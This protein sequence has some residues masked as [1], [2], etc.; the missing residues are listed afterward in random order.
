MSSY[1]FEGKFDEGSGSIKG[2]ISEKSSLV[3]SPIA[4][5]VVYCLCIVGGIIM[6]TKV[7][8]VAPFCIVPAV[9]AFIVMLIPILSAIGGGSFLV[10]FVS[11][12]YK[13]ADVLIG[14]FVAMFWIACI[15][16]ALSFA[17]L[18]GLG[19]GLMYFTFVSVIK[20][21]EKAGVLGGVL[22]IVVPFVVYLVVLA[23]S[24]DFL[25]SYFAIIP[26]ASIL[27]SLLLGEVANIYDFDLKMFCENKVLP[28]IKI[29]IYLCIVA[30]MFL[31]NTLVA[32]KKTELIQTA[33][34]YINESKYSEARA[35]LQDIKSE[36]AKE[37]Y[38][39]IR[40][41]GVQVGEI[42]YNGYYD[43]SDERSVSE[44]AIAFVCLDVVDNK[45]LFISLDVISLDENYNGVLSESVYTEDF[46]F[47]TNNMS[48][49]TIN[50]QESKFFLLSK[51][52]YEDYVGNEK[53]RD[54]LT[55]CKVS[56]YAQEQKEDVDEEKY[57]WTYPYT[58]FWLLNTFKTEGNTNYIGSI[59]CT[60]GN[61]EYQANLKV[62]AG[63][64]PCFYA[65]TN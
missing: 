31:M 20:S 8:E 23:L 47:D 10:K 39:S 26:T 42:I 17:A 49:I 4:I 22:S 15:F 40:Y 9:L 28:I 19:L 51:L 48:S 3:V 14:L 53:V 29:I 11:T 50:E 45:A 37:L 61:F 56:S 21:I 59:N 13:W 65:S 24:D 30:S 32:N 64:R 25:V 1:T 46:S 2:S 44:D 60:S 7:A 54:Y 33:K 55:K 5:F 27:I 36:E 43:D 34:A 12:F 57:K 58:E 6:L 63:I 38:A 41:K 16:E 52:Q 35:L 18:M 62:Y